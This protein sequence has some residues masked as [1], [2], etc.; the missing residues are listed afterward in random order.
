L[1]VSENGGRD[2]YMGIQLE[3]VAGFFLGV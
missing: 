1:G 2:L 3:Y